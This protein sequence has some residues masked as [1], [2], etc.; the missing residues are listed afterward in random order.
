MDRKPG[1][2]S[3]GVLDGHWWF[4]RFYFLLSREGYCIGDLG[5]RVRSPSSAGDVSRCKM[6]TYGRSLKAGRL[7]AGD[8]AL[9]S[10][11]GRAR[12]LGRHDTNECYES[13]FQI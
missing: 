1:E 2:T 8:R 6:M 13:P 5:G 9:L 11:D 10:C 12:D 4:H 3:W 7:G